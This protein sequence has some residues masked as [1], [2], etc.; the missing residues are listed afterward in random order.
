MPVLLKYYFCTDSLL[1]VVSKLQNSLLFKAWTPGSRKGTILPSKGTLIKGDFCIY[2]RKA[3]F[4]RQ[5][6]K[7]RKDSKANVCRSHRAQNWWLWVWLSPKTANQGLVQRQHFKTKSTW[8]PLMHFSL[9]TPDADT[10]V[11]MIKLLNHWVTF[12]RWGA[13]HSQWP[14]LSL[15]FQ[16]PKLPNP[17]CA[18]SPPGVHSR[19][20][21]CSE[22]SP[23]LSS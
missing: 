16:N 10:K 4:C 17:L 11:L 15:S 7:K 9:L 12:F 14:A 20:K 5:K 8:F 22:L 1:F 6:E 21:T 2:N 3:R 23:F 19:G 18:Q 13:F